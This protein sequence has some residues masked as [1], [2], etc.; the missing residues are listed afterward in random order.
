MTLSPDALTT[1]DTL[2]RR[3]TEHQ[4]AA[5]EK[6]IRATTDLRGATDQQTLNTLRE[7]ALAAT[8]RFIAAAARHF[9]CAARY[10]GPDN[11]RRNQYTCGGSAHDVAR[12]PRWA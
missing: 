12:G 8:D 4:P 7:S 2:W 1:A 9:A 6:A 3:L 11:C 5:A 10:A